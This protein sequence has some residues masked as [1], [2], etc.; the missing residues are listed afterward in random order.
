MFNPKEIKNSHT[1]YVCRNLYKQ[2]QLIPKTTLLV[3]A[4]L[5]YLFYR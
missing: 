5:L 2:T 3:G 1:S 4:V